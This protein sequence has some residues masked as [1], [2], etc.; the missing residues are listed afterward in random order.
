M[1]D[2]TPDLNPANEPATAAPAAPTGSGATAVAPSRTSRPLFGTIFWGIVL[3]TFAAFMVITTLFPVNLDPTLWLVG[4]V[5][6]IG[7]L[8][9]VAGIA[10]ASRRAG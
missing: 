6:V 5:I 7:L 9:V 8:L 10:A 1:S 4:S 2:A 3:L